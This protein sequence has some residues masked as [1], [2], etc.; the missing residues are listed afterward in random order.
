[1]IPKREVFGKLALDIKNHSSFSVQ[2]YNPGLLH[3]QDIIAS[4]YNVSANDIIED[5]PDNSG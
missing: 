3:K 5:L 2:R 1:M 4:V